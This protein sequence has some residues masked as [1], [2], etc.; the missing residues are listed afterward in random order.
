MHSYRRLEAWKQAHAALMLTL[1]A[2]D[3]AYHP[4]S[5]AMFDQIKRA[6]ISVEAQR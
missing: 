2:T 4:K 1:R 6:A 3:D 5:R